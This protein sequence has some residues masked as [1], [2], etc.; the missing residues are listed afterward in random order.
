[1]WLDTKKATRV[2]AALLLPRHV[3][4][5]SG[6]SSR[7]T[8]LVVLLSTTS[9]YW[10]RFQLGHL[11]LQLHDGS[12]CD[13]SYEIHSTRQWFTRFPALTERKLHMEFDI[14]Y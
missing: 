3:P 8:L 9:Y 7:N 14:Q 11:H 10:S 6:V 2:K 1:V 4:S 12:I 5:L 13:F